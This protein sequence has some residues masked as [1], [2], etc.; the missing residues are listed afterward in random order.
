MRKKEIIMIVSAFV[1]VVALTIGVGYALGATMF[2]KTPRFKALEI[3]NDN[4]D[5]G[6]YIEE[7]YVTVPNTGGRKVFCI[8]YT[9]QMGDGGGA[10]M[11]CNWNSFG[12]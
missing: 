4:G 2:D 9:D 1:C 10:G 5:H 8:V 7:Y 12:R 11:S 6:N 3:T